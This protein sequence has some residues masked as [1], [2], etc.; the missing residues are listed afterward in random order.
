VT[1]QASAQSN[2][3]PFLCLV[4]KACA[5]GGNPVAKS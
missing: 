4:F 2:V 3:K 1:F 5:F